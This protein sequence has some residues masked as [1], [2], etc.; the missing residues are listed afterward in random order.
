[1][2]KQKIFHE[3]CLFIL[4]DK[5]FNNKE[6]KGVFNATPDEEHNANFQITVI[7]VRD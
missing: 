3:F 4:M 6:R 2:Y 1:M 5:K 7:F